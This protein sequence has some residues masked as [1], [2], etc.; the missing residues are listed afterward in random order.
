[1]IAGVASTLITTPRLGMRRDS[2]RN[3]AKT[4]AAASMGL[5]LEERTSLS[6][7]ISSFPTRLAMAPR[8]EKP[9]VSRISRRRLEEGNRLCFRGIELFKGLMSS[10]VWE[11][12]GAVWEQHEPLWEVN[13]NHRSISPRYSR[14][15]ARYTVCLQESPWES[16][17]LKRLSY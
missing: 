5:G 11:S 17:P 8:T 12:T 13:H 7:C 15:P 1:M 6:K 16:G 10:T 9:S 3:M 4:S 14:L 2:F